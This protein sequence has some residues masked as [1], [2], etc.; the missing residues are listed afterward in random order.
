MA[1]ITQQEFRGG[2]SPPTTFMLRI[3]GMAL[4][5]AALGVWALN[6][7]AF[8]AFSTLVTL[9]ISTS[10]SVAAL[11]LWSRLFIAEHACICGENLQCSAR[12][13]L[14]GAEMAKTFLSSDVKID[15]QIKSN[16][17]IEIDGE[18]KGQIQA[19]AIKILYS[20]KV[21]GTVTCET[22]SV[23]GELS[24]TVGVADLTISSTG[25]VLADVQYS[26]LT[27]AKGAKL[28]GQLKVT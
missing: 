3:F 26:T 16:S 13:K 27:T 21:E 18:V 25:I 6:G 2:A 22:L 4:F 15:G 7:P 10:L 19:S 14:E 1:H 9:G 23:D 17:D 12:M 8:G 20:G 24:G 5:I 28:Q 11:F